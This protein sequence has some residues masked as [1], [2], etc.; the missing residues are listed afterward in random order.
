[1]AVHW[2]DVFAQQDQINLPG[3]VD[4]LPNWKRKLI[5]DLGDWKQDSRLI[6]ITAALRAEC[7]GRAG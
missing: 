4:E 3:T 2:E 5:V 6:A 1:M 7:R